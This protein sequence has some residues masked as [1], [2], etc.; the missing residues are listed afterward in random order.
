MGSAPAGSLKVATVCTVE[1]VPSAA[2]TV[3]PPV[4]TTFGSDTVAVLVAVCGVVV[5]WLIVTV[6]V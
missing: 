6:I 4:A 3:K 5:S 1:A 2:V